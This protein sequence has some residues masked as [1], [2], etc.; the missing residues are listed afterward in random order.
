MDQST[1]GRVFLR[2]QIH[3]K[4]A[5]RSIVHTTLLLHCDIYQNI[6][7]IA[8]QTDAKSKPS[9]HFCFIGSFFCLLIVSA[10]IEGVDFGSVHNGNDTKWEAAA[11]GAEDGPD[12]R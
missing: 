5:E 9:P 3:E 12:K 6:Q 2:L 8:D 10:S 4:K 7:Y 1:S 11:N